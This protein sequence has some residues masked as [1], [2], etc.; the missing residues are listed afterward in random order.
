MN[1]IEIYN[2]ELKEMFTRTYIRFNTEFEFFNHPEY[3]N[4]HNWLKSN[5]KI[6]IIFCNTKEGYGQL[7]I[8]NHI[9][10]FDI[11][12][13]FRYNGNEFKNKTMKDIEE[14][15]YKTMESLKHNRIEE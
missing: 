14:M 10:S 12:S 9:I 2:N 5:N 15:F 8:S 1:N 6:A 11:S 4:F 7:P 3:Y 13:N